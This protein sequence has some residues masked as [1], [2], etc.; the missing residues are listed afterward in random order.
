VVDSRSRAFDNYCAY[1]PPAIAHWGIVF[2]SR[3]HAGIVAELIER[4]ET[5][6]LLDIR[7]DP[8]ALVEFA[9]EQIGADEIGVLGFLM[10]QPAFEHG[11]SRSQEDALARFNR[12]PTRKT[13]VCFEVWDANFSALFAERSHDLQARCLEMHAVVRSQAQ[14][15]YSFGLDRRNDLQIDCDQGHWVTQTGFED[16]DYILPTGEIATCPRSVSGVASPDGW[17]IGTLPLGAKYG[18]LSPGDI[19]LRFSE[20]RIV[21]ITGSNRKLCADFETVLTKLPA[22]VNVS[23]AGVGMSL[24]IANAATTH[25]AGHLWH[26]RHYGFHLGLG[27]RLPQTDHPTIERTG[28]HLDIVFAHGALR[29]ANGTDMLTW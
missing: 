28:H 25:P 13:K 19:V 8:Q 5:T 11:Y 22:L 23:E 12:W 9:R 29:G 1:L 14:I 21:E 16:D 26:E 24:A 18:R 3:F 4:L 27:A 6:T 10:N 2:D 7:K 20:G 15:S 17:I